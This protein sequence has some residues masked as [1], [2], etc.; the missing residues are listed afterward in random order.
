MSRPCL[1]RRTMLKGLGG[2]TISLPFLEEMSLWAATPGKQAVIPTRAFNLFFGLGVPAPLQEE[3]FKGVLEPLHSL[4]DKL[5]IMRGVDHVRCDEKGINAHF[6]GSSAA[7]TAS[8]PNGEAKA[9]G[10]SIDQLV[11][12]SKPT[13]PPA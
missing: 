2:I 12:R 9:G 3:G 1:S 6:D 4:R 11:R 7:F 5:L 13:F 8:A 10:A